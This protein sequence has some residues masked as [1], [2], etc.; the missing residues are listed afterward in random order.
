MASAAAGKKKKKEK[1][2]K[3]K[4]RLLIMTEKKMG[5]EL[6]RKKKKK[7]AVRIQRSL[8]FQCFFGQNAGVARTQ[9]KKKP[10]SVDQRGG[11]H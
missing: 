1:M 2:K 3:K 11:N 8:T 4:G 5:G 7:K 6:E 9:K 10:S